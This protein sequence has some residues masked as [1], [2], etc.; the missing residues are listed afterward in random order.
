MNVD[1]NILSR[2]KILEKQNGFV[3]IGID[4]FGGSGKT[5]LAQFI[6]NSLPNTRIIEMDDFYSPKL[7]RADIERVSAQVL[8]PLS[9]FETSR[10][11]I[12]LWKE[13]KFVDADPINRKG[14]VIIEGVFSLSSEL[15]KYYDIKIWVDC[16]SDIAMERGILRDGEEVRNKWVNEWLPSEKEYVAT[17]N[18]KV[19]A[20]FVVDSIKK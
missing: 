11:Q 4:G 19:K 20:D 10:Y 1:Q 18:P 8:K 15:E 12:Y 5:H 2:I 16:P 9:K 17:Q 7:K 13:D 14:V 6:K 3:L